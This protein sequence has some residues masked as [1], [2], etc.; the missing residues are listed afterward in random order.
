MRRLGVT[1]GGA[2]EMV[3]RLRIEARHHARLARCRAGSDEVDMSM[4]PGRQRLMLDH[5][6]TLRDFT[7]PDP[8]TLLRLRGAFPARHAIGGMREIDSAR[9]MSLLE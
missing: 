9:S 7:P 6:S 1:R 8:F 2:F 5:V 4:R 3:L